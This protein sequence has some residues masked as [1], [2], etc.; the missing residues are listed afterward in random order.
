MK[1][2]VGVQI[3]LYTSVTEA[4][5]ESELRATSL[6]FSTPLGRSLWLRVWIYP[7]VNKYVE[8]M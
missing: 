1:M 7:R 5:G 2:H 3:W 8:E 6:G 4:Q